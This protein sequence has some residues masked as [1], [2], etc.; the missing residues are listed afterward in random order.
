MK[1]KTNRI[2]A[3]TDGIFAIVMTIMMVSMSELMKFDK[4]AKEEDYH[5]LFAGM[6]GDF[7]SYAISFMLLGVLWLAHHWQFQYISYID[8]PLVFINI[9]WFM[10]ICLIPFSAMML[11]DHPDFFAP[12]LAFECNILIVFLILYAQWAYVTKRKHLVE[13]SL[14]T[15]TISRQRNIVLSLITIMI[16]AIAV[17]Y[18]YHLLLK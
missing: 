15:K 18:G 5:R 8:P 14:D 12:V 13:P 6:W 9:I 11:G 4:S 2:E 16:A 3:L 10:F 1:L 7:A 17:S